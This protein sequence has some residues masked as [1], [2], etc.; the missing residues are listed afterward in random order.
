MEIPGVLVERLG[1]V[2]LFA[3]DVDGVLTEAR[4]EMGGN[5]PERKVFHIRDGLGLRLLQ[6][7]GLKVAWVSA[8]PSAATTERAEDLKVD[9]L[10]QSST[11]KVALIEEIQRELGVGWAETL[12]MGD[13]VV[14]LGALR[15]AGFAAV[16][17]DGIL[18][19]R[20]LAHYVCRLGGGCGA[21]R[22][23]VDL[24]LK[25]QGRWAGLIEKFTS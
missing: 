16:P 2:R 5:L 19:A 25:A 4:V 15:R 3:C 9:F 22:E 13:D 1:R 14:D 18:E 20:T 21:V 10:R 6:G 23:V 12:Y 24:V 7:E 8:R 17:S 11:P